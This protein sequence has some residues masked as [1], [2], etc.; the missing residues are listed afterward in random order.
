MYIES[1][2]GWQG[3]SP[4]NHIC[5]HYLSEIPTL[6]GRGA[7]GRTMTYLASPTARRR[8]TEPPCH[9]QKLAGDLGF[10]LCPPRPTGP[11]FAGQGTLF[12]TSIWVLAGYGWG[13]QCDSPVSRRQLKDMGSDR[14]WDRTGSFPHLRSPSHPI[15]SHPIPIHMYLPDVPSRFPRASSW[16][17]VGDA[18]YLP[19]GPSTKYSPLCHVS[20]SSD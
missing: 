10:A 1:S 15:P 3:S 20:I 4:P 19:L 2:A 5:R 17:V 6:A 13:G 7:A 16:C 18:M 12:P 8:T 9:L 14:V 11:A